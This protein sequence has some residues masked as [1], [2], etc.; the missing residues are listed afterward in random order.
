MNRNIWIEKLEITDPEKKEF[1]KVRCEC[2]EVV[3]VSEKNLIKKEK[4]IH[5]YKR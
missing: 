1:K 3:S 2:Y 4:N 5:S